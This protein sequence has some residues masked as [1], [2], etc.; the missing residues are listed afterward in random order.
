MLSRGKVIITDRL[1]GHILSLLLGIEHI[2]LDNNYGKLSS[3]YESWT[4]A[5]DLAHWARSPEE[6][7]ALARDL[8]RR[9]PL[10]HS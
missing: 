7:A 6:A 10:P 3:F 2:V 9:S 4:R 8:V 1:H 5:S